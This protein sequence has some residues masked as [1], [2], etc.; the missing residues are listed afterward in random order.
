MLYR[1]VQ[2]AATGQAKRVWEADPG[3][4]PAL[5]AGEAEFLRVSDW[6]M[7]RS[8]WR[9]RALAGAVVLALVAGLVIAVVAGQNART[10]AGQQNAAA[11]IPE[12]LA[13]QSTALD[14]AD[15]V[16][17][18]LLAAAAVQLRRPRRPGTACSNRSSSR[19][20]AS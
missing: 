11:L 3:R 18:A 2:L 5:S 14:A 1:G 7:T 8:R 16:T 12:R 9:R 10:T 15:P 4:F 20:A 13:A 6:A 19:S 17:A